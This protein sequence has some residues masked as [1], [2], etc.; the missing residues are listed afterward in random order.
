ML[1]CSPTSVC[2]SFSD[3]VYQNSELTATQE[4][5]LLPQVTAKAVQE[6]YEGVNKG[7]Q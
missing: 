4:N 3:S 5:Q 1:T 7:K 2:K 6:K